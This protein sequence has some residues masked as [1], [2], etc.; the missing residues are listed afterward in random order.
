MAAYGNDNFIYIALFM[1]SNLNVL[2][3]GSEK[4]L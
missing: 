2:Y 1:T 3:I 4:I